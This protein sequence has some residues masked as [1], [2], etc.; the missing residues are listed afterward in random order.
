MKCSFCGK[1]TRMTC[2]DS[3]G[4]LFNCCLDCKKS[5]KL[6]VS[7]VYKKGGR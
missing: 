1:E 6:N 4:R 2:R 5:K 7:A 3:K